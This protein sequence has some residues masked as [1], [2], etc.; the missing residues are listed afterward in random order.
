MKTLI[1][2]EDIARVRLSENHAT[3]YLRVTYTD[4][5]YSEWAAEHYEESMSQ[6]EKCKQL[7]QAYNDIADACKNKK[8]FVEF[9]IDR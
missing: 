3:D 2:T 4:G 8:E 5:T 6:R 7:K 9:E 1:R